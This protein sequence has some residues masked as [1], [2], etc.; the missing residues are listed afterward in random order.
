M[1]L[2]IKPIEIVMQGKHQLLAKA[3]HWERVDL[4]NVA[5]VQNGFAF[6]SELFTHSDGMPLVRIRD[7]DK[8]ITENFYSGTYLNDFVVRKGD[9]LIGMDGD[10]NAAIWQGSDG[11][12]N[13][14]VC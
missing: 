2:S 12:L 5:I 10:F 4:S 7:I 13:Q 6:K 9:F 3:E 14:R 1:A 8:G 11:L